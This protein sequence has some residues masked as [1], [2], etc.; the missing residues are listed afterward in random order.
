[1]CFTLLHATPPVFGILCVVLRS[2]FRRLLDQNTHYP[3][4]CPS[5]LHAYAR[6]LNLS[7]ATIPEEMIRRLLIP[8]YH[9]ALHFDPVS[10]EFPDT[11]P[12]F[13][14]QPAFNYAALVLTP[15][16]FQ[17]TTARFE[18]WPLSG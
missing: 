9:L 5:P 12:I 10:Q 17:L 4:T 14:G 6:T 13:L 16:S 8:D 1:M 11:I 7:P 2:G 15:W 18:R 3:S